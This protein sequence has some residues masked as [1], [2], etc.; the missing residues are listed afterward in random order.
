M[1]KKGSA[2]KSSDS[3]LERIG[4]EAI[5]NEGAPASLVEKVLQDDDNGNNGDDDK[6]KPFEI[7]PPVKYAKSVAQIVS[8]EANP[9]LQPVSYQELQGFHSHGDPTVV[10]VKLAN[11]ETQTHTYNRCRL[12]R[13]KNGF[14]YFPESDPI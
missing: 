6:F 9:P 12:I 1:K 11:G 13:I 8:I 2:K 5:C 4:R 14:V 10:T 3:L 7:G